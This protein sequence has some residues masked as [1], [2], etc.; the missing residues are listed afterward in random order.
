VETP[1]ATQASLR[2]ALTLPKVQV[3]NAISGVFDGHSAAGQMIPATGQSFRTSAAVGFENRL[4]FRF[5]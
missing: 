1:D 2:E 4:E 3:F 5:G